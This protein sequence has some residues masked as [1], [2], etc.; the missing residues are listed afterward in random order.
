MRV[1]IF[2]ALAAVGVAGSPVAAQTIEQGEVKF[3]VLGRVQAQFSTT[4]IDEGELIAA[5]HV[6]SAAIPASQF[7]TRRVRLGAEAVF[8]GW[9]TGK[10]ESEL[11]MAR[12]QIRDAYLNMAFDPAFQLRMGQFKKPFSLLQLTSSSVWPVIERGVR[13]RGLG[14]S[15]FQQDSAAGGAPVMQSF[16]SLPVL[17]EEQDLLDVFLYQNFDLGA[18]VHGEFDGFGYSVG[19]FNGSGFDRPDDTDGKSFAGRVTYKLPTTWPVT[20]G[21]AVSHR[22]F[23]VTNRPAIQTEGGTAFEADVEMGAFRKQGLHFLGEVVVGENLAQP[24]D[25]FLGAQGILSYFHPTEGKVE[26]LEFAGRVSYGD[27]RRDISDDEGLLLTPG[28]NLYF[29]GRNR[30]MFNWDVFLTSDRFTTENALRAQAQF[31]F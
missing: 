3:K 12:L 13:I 17:S 23:R 21:A 26:G 7:E 4:S 28:V 29:F 15:M 11:A 27:A 8:R 20:L 9:L 14:V 2:A 22:E 25:D 5:G 16:G 31:Y 30:L 1:W 24:D 10:L 18:V 19:V 6:P